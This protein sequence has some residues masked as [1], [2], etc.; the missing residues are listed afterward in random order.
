MCATPVGTEQAND[1]RAVTPPDS[2]ILESIDG[3]DSDSGLN[4][5]DIGLVVTSDL[6]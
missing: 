1:I 5:S 6:E 2:E 4:V 3:D